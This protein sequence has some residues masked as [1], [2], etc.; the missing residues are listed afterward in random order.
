MTI[1]YGQRCKTR[2]SCERLSFLIVNVHFEP[3]LTLRNL[4]ERLCLIT[5]H[6][7]QYPDAICIIMG[8]FNICEPEEG[9]FKMFGVKLSF[10]DGDTGKAASFHFLFPRV[11]EGAQP[12]HTR[13]DL[14]VN[15]V[16]ARYQELI[17]PLSVFLCCWNSTQAL[18]N[19]LMAVARDF[20]CY[21][22]VFENLRKRSIPSD[23]AAVG[24]VIQKPTIRTRQV[25]RN[26]SWMSKHP[27]FC[28][29]LKQINDDHRFPVAPFCALADF[30]TILEKAKRQTVSE[31]SHKTPVSLGAKLLTASTASRAFRNRHL[32][33]LMRCCEAWEAVGKCFDPVSFE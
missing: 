10:T 1:P 6:W 17:E 31:L 29:I 26:P 25:K 27:G 18:I 13:R 19:M 23:H 7:P 32:G 21:S 11:L 16:N 30:K 20:H 3:E 9:R 14:S 22:H 28:S 8:H 12:D 15:G 33:T 24:V 2:L 5:P 4:R